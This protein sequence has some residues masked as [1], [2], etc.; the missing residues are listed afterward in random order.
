MSTSSKPRANNDEILLLITIRRQAAWESMR[1]IVEGF[2][3]PPHLVPSIVLLSNYFMNMVFCIELM[4]KLLSDNWRSHDIESMYQSAFGKSHPSPQ[5]MQEIKSAILDQKYLFEPA[6]G[7][8]GRVPDLESLYD[9]VLSKLKEKFP[10]FSIDRTVSL[11]KSFTEYIIGHA[12]RFCRFQ[13]PSFGPSNPPSADFWKKHVA[14]SHRQL[15][16]VSQSFRD[17]ADKFNTFECKTHL[18]SLT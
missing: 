8:D 18:E 14:E 3:T 17:H 10:G 6:S 13:S 16:Q 9:E 11:P 1:Q 12:A 15:Q 7:L 2:G 4:L 5:L